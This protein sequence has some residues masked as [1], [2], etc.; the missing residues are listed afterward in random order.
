MWEKKINLRRGQENYQWRQELLHKYVL[1]SCFLFWKI[2][3]LMTISQE[4]SGI[5]PDWG[6]GVAESVD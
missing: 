5:I 3:V 6:H 2:P 1:L 4:L